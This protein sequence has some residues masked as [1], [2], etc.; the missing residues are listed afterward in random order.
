MSLDTNTRVR[1]ETPPVTA[2]ASTTATPSAD[3][4]CRRATRVTNAAPASEPNA[5]TSNQI[6]PTS[7]IV[8]T[9]S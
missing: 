2:I 5:I 9:D 8:P 4:R 7:P 6:R 1:L 3:Q